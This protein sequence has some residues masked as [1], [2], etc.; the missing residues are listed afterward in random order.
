[1]QT[2]LETRRID[3]SWLARSNGRKGTAVVPWRKDR[4]WILPL[5]SWP[6]SIAL[7]KLS[8]LI[9]LAVLCAQPILGIVLSSLA[10]LIF[11]TLFVRRDN[12]L[13]LRVVM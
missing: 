13:L 5:L 4:L 8:R 6:I 9:L 7:A 2:G 3:G 11:L 1:M 12:E 10:V